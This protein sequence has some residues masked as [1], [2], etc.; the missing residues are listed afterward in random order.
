MNTNLQKKLLL[1]VALIM[2]PV[3]YLIVRAIPAPWKLV[4]DTIFS[5]V[6]LFAGLSV[7]LFPSYY[8]GSTTTLQATNNPVL[9]LLV[10]G[11]CILNSLGG[12]R[13]VTALLWVLCLMFGM[14]ALMDL[15][16]AGM[17][18]GFSKWIICLVD[19]P[20]AAC[21]NFAVILQPMA[22]YGS[23]R[24][25]MY[26]LESA[27]A[28]NNG[29]VRGLS[30][31]GRQA[32]SEYERDKVTSLLRLCASL[33]FLDGAVYWFI[34]SLKVQTFGHWWSFAC[35]L[36]AFACFA[37]IFLSGQVAQSSKKYTP[38]FKPELS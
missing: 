17:Q 10:I 27:T 33:V 28:T 29:S 14:G 4:L 37:S 1:A 32:T 15:V 13:A 11:R 24:H 31:S 3:F 38:A 23:V 2:L 25:D 9:L 6:I 22:D 36:G 12:R 20:I 21:F 7:A 18:G 26:A 35:S 8:D 30:Q 34:T 19:F 5:L 16:G